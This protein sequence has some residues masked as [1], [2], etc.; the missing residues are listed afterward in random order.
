MEPHF[1][2]KGFEGIRT[3][4]FHR[5]DN[6]RYSRARNR[7]DDEI[8]AKWSMRICSLAFFLEISGAS[9]TDAW[10]AS[11]PPSSR[12]QREKIGKTKEGKKL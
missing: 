8:T 9:G 6:H 3:G 11:T 2:R 4:T 1:R 12:C 10:P 5:K 7:C